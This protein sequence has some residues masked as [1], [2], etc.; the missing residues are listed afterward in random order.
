MMA[1]GLSDQPGAELVYGSPARLADL[2]R[3]G[4]LDAAFVSS[5]E[6]YNGDYVIIPGCAVSSRGKGADATLFSN[7]PLDLLRTVALDT[8]SRSTN[9]LLRLALHWLRPGAAVSYGIRPA[10]S[11][12][13][14]REFDGC[15]LIGDVALSQCHSAEHRYDLAQIW[16]D[17]TGLPMVLTL[18]LARPDADP[19]LT[20]TIAR[21]FARGCEQLEEIATEAA[22]DRGW[23]REFVR[24]YL[25]ETLDFGWRAEH[26]QSLQLF[27]EAL[28]K[29]DLVEH[30]HPL[31]YLGDSAESA[32]DSAPPAS[33]GAGKG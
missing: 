31:R 33:T 7:V 16:S 9:L 14:L 1:R 10:D 24:H 17:R 6:Y 3:A 12:R 22:F 30:L 15:L 25:T 2:L 27:G 23:P 21:A 5:S 8:A 32:A 13:S 11:C 29:L 19:A 4:R 18:W 20:G 28:Y 26:E